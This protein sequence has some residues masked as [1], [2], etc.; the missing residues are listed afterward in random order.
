MALTLFMEAKRVIVEYIGKKFL[1]HG[2]K[3]RAEMG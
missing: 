1:F 2:R 3:L